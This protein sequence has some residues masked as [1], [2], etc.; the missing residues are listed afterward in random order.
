MPGPG[1]ASLPLALWVE[2]GLRWALTWS[3][4]MCFLGL[5]QGPE[6]MHGR[7]GHLGAERVK[8]VERINPGVPRH[9]FLILL[10][11]C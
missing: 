5:G 6:R 10:R 4:A 9:L 11:A 3:S 2:L 8:V 7:M 1:P